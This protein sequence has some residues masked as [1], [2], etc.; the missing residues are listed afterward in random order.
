[1]TIVYRDE[2]G[3]IARSVDGDGVDMADGFAYFADMDGNDYKI[4]LS[5]ILRIVEVK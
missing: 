3:T 4:P 1:M 2:V 5:E